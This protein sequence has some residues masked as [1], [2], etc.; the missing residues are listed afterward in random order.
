M[1]Y[2]INNIE[3][4]GWLGNLGFFLGAIYLTKIKRFG[5]LWQMY[6]NWMY[7]IIGFESEIYSLLFLDSLLFIVNIIGWWK[8]RK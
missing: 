3:I 5:W 4:V 1:I 6:G 7:M 8:W 2:L